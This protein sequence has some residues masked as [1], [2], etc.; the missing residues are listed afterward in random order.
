MMWCLNGSSGKAQYYT[1]ATN[2]KQSIIYVYEQNTSVEWTRI[3]WLY[4]K[5]YQFGGLWQLEQKLLTVET[6][7]SQAMRD[8]LYKGWGIMSRP[9]P[10]AQGWETDIFKIEIMKCHMRWYT[11]RCNKLWLLKTACFLTNSPTPNPPRQQM[12]H[13]AALLK[14]LVST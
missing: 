11:F 6:W 7:I 10:P 14:L 5:M 12:A 13:G 4:L 3:E 1:V 8:L 9:M 2:R